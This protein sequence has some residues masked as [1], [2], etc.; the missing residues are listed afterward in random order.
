MA[1][2]SP[3]DDT[4]SIQP[5]SDPRAIAR[6]NLLRPS[7][8]VARPESIGPYRILETLGE[9]GMGVVYLAEQSK[10]IH[11]RVA[12]K[13]IKLGMD[14][15]QVIAR[16]ETEREALALMNHPNVAKVFDAG[17]TEMGRPYFAMEYV[18]GIPIT[19]YCDKHRLTT[20]ERLRLFMDVCNA[21]QHAHQK[22]I[23]HRDIKPSNVLI[24]VEE[25]AIRAATVR[26]RSPGAVVKVID[27]GIAKA[28]QQRLSEMTFSTQEGQFIGTPAYVSPEQAGGSPHDVDIRTD[29][30][31]LGVL[32]YELLVGLRPFDD[33]LLRSAALSEIQRI[34]REVEPPKPS[35]RVSNIGDLSTP[36]AQN[37]GTQFRTLASQLRGDLDWIVMKCL[38]KDR[39]RRYPSATE[40]AAEVQRFLAH[41]PV[42]AGPPSASYRVKKFVRRNRLQV[43][44]ASAI[45][46]ALTAGLAGTTY[47]LVRSVRAGAAE[48]KQREIAEARE[49]DADQ[50]RE[51]A[52]LVLD[53][54]I[55]TLRAADPARQGKDVT[56]RELLDRTDQTITH[57]F[58]SS[59]PTEAR[60]RATLGWTYR[61]LGIYESAEA[62]LA[63]ATDIYT[64]A[65]GNRHPHTLDAIQYYAEVLNDRGSYSRAED[66]SRN[67]L[68]TALGALGKE[69]RVTLGLTR[70]LA[71]ALLYQ[72]RIAEAAAL[73]SSVLEPMRRVLG[74][75]HGETLDAVNDLGVCL[76][77]MGRHAQAEELFREAFEGRQRVLGDAHPAT[78]GSMTSLA[79][80][81]KERGRYSDAA[82]LEQKV[83]EVSLRVL[84]DEHPN[85]LQ[86][87]NNLAWSLAELAR[88]SEAEELFRK[89]L[90][91]RRRV[92]G[93]EHPQT[94]ES[95]DALAKSL[96][97]LT[98]FSEAEEL[99]R[100]ALEIR[101]HVLGEK[102]PVTLQSMHDLG[103]VLQWQGQHLASEAV[104]YETLQKRREV[105]GEEHLD[106]LWSK[107]CLAV[108]FHAQGRYDEAQQFNESVLAVRRRVLGDKHPDTLQAMGELAENLIA[109]RNPSKAEPLLIEAWNG[110]ENMPFV[111]A[112]RKHAILELIVSLYDSWDAAEPGKGYAE[113]A[114]EWRAMLEESSKNQNAETSKP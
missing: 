44:A 78:L 108:A 82:E 39:T 63:Q 30:Y 21:I 31:S 4:Q 75:E 17:A 105:L 60:V 86:S 33:L 22:G 107:A 38:E 96:S 70:A 37:R 79:V 2:N 109:G 71:R 95:M 98:R 25:V 5:A 102:H 65:L 61:Q 42:V 49:R 46:V 104:Y 12:L 110:L 13:I 94:L 84:G 40:L 77:L 43:A 68:Q 26:E 106:T 58:A 67:A 8:A 54:F 24:A 81:L 56:V 41:Q 101:R 15:K 34:I 66:L 85:T 47:G 69:H 83:I 14:T 64:H 45:T 111:G 74:G 73:Y 72:Q 97:D 50:A 51:E 27:F 52:E 76:A 88:F 57:R 100:K 18:A 87:M 91:I 23:I 55:D 36:I 1:P 59:L 90:E 35:A 6:Q 93:E 11:R 48:V 114:A 103:L 10:P 113:K 3:H 53:F 9:G 62:H 16:F 7:D 20:E 89:T 112:Q 99:H 29:V 92:L 32:L 19:D 80:N 28:T